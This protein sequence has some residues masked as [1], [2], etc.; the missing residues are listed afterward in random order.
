M[1]PGVLRK[2][3]EGLHVSFLVLEAM[4]L[5][6]MM[7]RLDK[8]LGPLLGVGTIDPLHIV[9][10]RFHHRN[11]LVLREPACIVGSVCSVKGAMSTFIMALMISSMFTKLRSSLT[12]N[13]KLRASFDWSMLT[14]D[15][16]SQYPPIH[17]FPL[18]PSSP[19]SLQ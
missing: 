14:C 11:I 7:V 5:V 13:G 3:G 18:L 17:H 4:S 19:A 2:V 6:D 12:Q 8:C 1:W 9:S 15:P 16:L 10:V